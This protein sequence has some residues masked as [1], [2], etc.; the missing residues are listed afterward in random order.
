MRCE[1]GCKSFRN[2]GLGDFLLM[3]RRQLAR[4]VLLGTIATATHKPKTLRAP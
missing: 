2:E 4:K 1:F 3:L